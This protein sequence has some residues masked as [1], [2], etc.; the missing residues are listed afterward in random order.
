MSAIF[1][2]TCNYARCVGT[3]SIR[4][5][6][7]LLADYDKRI[8]GVSDLASLVTHI[9]RQVLPA[10]EHV[11]KSV[12]PLGCLVPLT[13]SFTV[14]GCLF[15][16]WVNAFETPRGFH[17]FL[18]G[19]ASTDLR[20]GRNLELAGAAFFIPTG[21][22]N[23][24]LYFQSYNVA[25]FQF[26]D[27]CAASIGQVRVFRYAPQVAQLMQKLP[28]LNAIHNLAERAATL[29]HVQ[30]FSSSSQIVMGTV[31]MT[32]LLFGY[33]CV[34][35]Q[36]HININKYHA[37]VE[38]YEN[39]LLKL[40]ITC[41]DSIKFAKKLERNQCKERANINNRNVYAGKFAVYFASF[42]LGITNV[43]VMGALGAVT[44]GLV[45]YKAYHKQENDPGPS[46]KN[47]NK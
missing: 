13:S 10:L 47:S 31:L 42:A 7:K 35:T 1:E 17:Y 46:L 21:V 6:Q 28:I 2:R 26:L 22:L 40:G 14:L 20:K 41:T 12:G 4:S 30:V 8:E 9:A 38:I 3:Y 43:Y 25:S 44:A 29:S 39:R 23:S 24:I 18:G 36:A 45:C 27:K 11:F 15:A 16:D 34:G 5:G 33:V 32:T 37:K 19:C